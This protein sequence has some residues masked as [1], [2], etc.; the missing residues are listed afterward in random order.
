M[1]P[2][3]NNYTPEFKRSAVQ[4]AEK[5][6]SLTKTSKSLKISVSLLSRWRSE[7]NKYGK[8]SFPGRGKQKMTDNEKEIAR[9]KKALKK[10]E[11][12]RDLL[13]KTVEIFIGK[14]KRKN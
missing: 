3:R 2:N 13:K 9:L 4:H 5:T 1:K 10:A 7:I 11:F 8:N 12:E 6:R 14:P